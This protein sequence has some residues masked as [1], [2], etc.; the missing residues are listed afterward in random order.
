M[1]SFK[2]TTEMEFVKEICCACSC[3]FWL[4]KQLQINLRE[5]KQSFYCYN[6]HPQSYRKSTA[7]IL[8]EEHEVKMAEKERQL[9][10]ADRLNENLANRLKN[11]EKP[12]ESKPKRKALRINH[13]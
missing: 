12:F 4:P 10:S 2:D 13:T 7:D 6:G 9:Q 3:I 8:K 5:N 1:S 11:L